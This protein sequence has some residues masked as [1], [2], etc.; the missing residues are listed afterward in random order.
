MVE[1]ENWKTQN[2]AASGADSSLIFAITSGAPTKVLSVS[3]TNVNRTEIT[4]TWSAPLSNG[5]S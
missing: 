3:Q 5:G 2:S 4:L 1:V